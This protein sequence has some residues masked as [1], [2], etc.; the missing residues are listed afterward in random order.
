MKQSTRKPRK[1][2]GN[3]VLKT[4]PDPVME[5]IYNRCDKG[6]Q[7]DVL[8]W[9]K[10]VHGIKV[11]DTTL[12]KFS[13]WYGATRFVRQAS[14]LSA[15]FEDWVKNALPTISPDELADLGQ[16][17]FMATAIR[18]GDGEAFEKFA[19]TLARLKT[20]RASEL[21]SK[22]AWEKWEKA[23][24]VVE[25]AQRT[26]EGGLTAETLQKIEKQLKML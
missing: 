6:L 26:P 7:K 21:K 23:K 15:S 24:A 8:K 12:S 10:D 19:N 25:T 20:A 13:H 14:H 11:S 17:A 2:N 3:S 9:L 1:P 18:D 4:L 22:E 16:Q 5:E